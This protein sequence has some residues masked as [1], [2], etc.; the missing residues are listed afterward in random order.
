M[1][2]GPVGAKSTRTFGKF[3]L[4]K[5]A[6]GTVKMFDNRFSIKIQYYYSCNCTVFD[7]DSMALY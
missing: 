7:A 2:T 6:T 5:P 1:Q 3:I 4:K